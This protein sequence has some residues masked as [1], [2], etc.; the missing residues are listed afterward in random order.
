MNELITV[1]TNTQTVSARDLHEALGISERFSLWA[2]RYQDLM[3][4]YGVTPR[5]QTYGGSKQRRNST[6]GAYRLRSS[7]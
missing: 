4:E 7:R 3:N 2:S 6:H 1:D 5:R